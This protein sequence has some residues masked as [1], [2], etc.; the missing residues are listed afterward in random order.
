MSVFIAKDDTQNIDPNSEVKSEPLTKKN[1]ADLA[2]PKFSMPRAPT[3]KCNIKV[4][5]DYTYFEQNAFTL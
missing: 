2:N 5:L 1:G 4:S 3:D